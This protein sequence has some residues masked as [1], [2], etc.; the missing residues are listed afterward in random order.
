MFLLK[1]SVPVLLLSLLL[2]A[3][4]VSIAQAQIYIPPAAPPMPHW[5]GGYSDSWSRNCKRD[6]DGNAVDTRTGDVYDWN[7]GRLIRRGNGAPVRTQNTP[8]RQSTP[9]SYK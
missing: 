7:T 3:S 1:K 5:C 8:Y 4:I 9:S 6:A 2:P